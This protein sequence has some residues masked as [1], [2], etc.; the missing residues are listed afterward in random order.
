MLGSILVYLIPGALSGF[1]AGL[2]GIGGGIIVVPSLLFI[3]SI[4]HIPESHILHLAL[5]TSMGSILFTSVSSFRAHHLRGSVNWSVFRSIV[6]GVLFGTGTGTIIAGY[7]NTSLLK[8]FFF[9]FLVY[10]ATQI[11]FHSS[12]RT[13]W[14]LPGKAGMFLAGVVIGGISSLVGIGGGTLSVP[15]ML[16][17]NVKIHEAIGTSAAIG[18]PIAVSGTLG[19]ILNGFWVKDLPP[20]SC[21]Y[22]YV[23]ALIGIVLT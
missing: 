4:N 5:G 23:P 15:L 14:K 18:F 9:L 8:L 3:F 16:R 1:L 11:L 10:T 19:Y 22:L 12:T 7:L 6:P 20:Y 17:S 21:G 13:F 2:F